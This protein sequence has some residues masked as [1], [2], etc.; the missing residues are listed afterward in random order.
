[1]SILIED[2]I[3]AEPKRKRGR[4]KGSRNKPTAIEEEI[5]DSSEAE[6]DIRSVDEGSESENDSSC[7]QD[8][9]LE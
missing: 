4:P 2:Q 7:S 6:T 3:P 9:N 5:D 8:S 1:M